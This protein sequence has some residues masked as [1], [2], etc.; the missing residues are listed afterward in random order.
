[1]GKIGDVAYKLNDKEKAYQVYEQDFEDYI[2]YQTT[3][4]VV[5]APTEDE[6]ALEDITMELTKSGDGS[7]DLTKW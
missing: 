1:M 2:N 4:T 3:L 6:L 7:Y 5:S